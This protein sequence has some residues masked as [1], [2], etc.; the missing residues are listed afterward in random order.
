M[1]V[2]Q[3]WELTPELI[4]NVASFTAADTGVKAN[5]A[6]T[7]DLW[8]R[9]VTSGPLSATRRNFLLVSFRLD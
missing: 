9:T 7:T 6:A 4:A 3:E 1:L 8:L 2:H 5:V